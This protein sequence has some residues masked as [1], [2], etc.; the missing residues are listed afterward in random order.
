MIDIEEHRSCISSH[1]NPIER[2][3][4]QH[5][6]ERERISIVAIEAD[7]T[8]P[9]SDKQILIAIPI[10]I[11]ERGMRVIPDIDRRNKI[12][13]PE[14]KVRIRRSADVFIIPES[15]SPHVV[16]YTGEQVEVAVAIDIDEIRLVETECYER[17][18]GR[19]PARH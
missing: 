1:R 5:G 8:V 10:D 16:E 11:D 14:L 19:I 9:F 12:F 17:S 13:R 18:T 7:L 2:G 3:S 4:D 15:M 6:I